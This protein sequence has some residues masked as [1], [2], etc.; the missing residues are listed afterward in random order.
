MPWEFSEDRALPL[1]LLSVGF[2]DGVTSGVCTPGPGPSRVRLTGP[3][4]PL[5]PA[6]EPRQVVCGK[7]R[8]GQEA[9]LPQDPQQSRVPLFPTRAASS[10]AAN[11]PR[12][13][14]RI[15]QVSAAPLR[16]PGDSHA[17]VAETARESPRGGDTSLR[18]GRDAVSGAET[19]A[20][21]RLPKSE[22]EGVSAQRGSRPPGT[23]AARALKRRILAGAN[24]HRVPRGALRLPS[25]SRSGR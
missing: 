2:R 15:S 6:G 1:L 4:P 25:G 12:G 24:A 16:S 5:R 3:Q 19:R 14:H 17:E 9:P 13:T 8:G 21:P 11:P 20:G 7:E 22:V 18:V 10:P 23:R